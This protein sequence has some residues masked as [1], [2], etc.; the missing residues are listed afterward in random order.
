[1]RIYELWSTA[2]E[3][4]RTIDVIRAWGSE[5]ATLKQQAHTSLPLEDG[6]ALLRSVRLERRRNGYTRI[7]DWTSDDGAR[8]YERWIAPSRPR[9]PNAR[10]LEL[11]PFGSPPA[12]SPLEGAP[13]KR[14]A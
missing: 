14:S 3:L 8:H 13:A 9:P 6:A 12:T 2:F 1:M 7:V 11:W 5:G 10:Q 4:A